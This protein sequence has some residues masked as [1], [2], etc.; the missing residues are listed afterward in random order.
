MIIKELYDEYVC[1]IQEID[2]E[3]ARLQGKREVYSNI[4]LDLYNIIQEQEKVQID[5]NRTQF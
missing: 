2:K 5:E 3:I 1:R 4:R